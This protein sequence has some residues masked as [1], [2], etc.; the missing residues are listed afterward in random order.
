MIL[1]KSHQDKSQPSVREVVVITGGGSG[2]GLSAAKYM[3]KNKLIILSGRTMSKLEK[4]VSELEA[5]GY[6]ALAHTCD[7]SSRRSVHELA[8]FAALQGRITNVINAA[9]L[10]PSMADPETLLRV[11]ALGTMYINQ[12]FA[13]VMHSGS[14]IL[15]VSSNSAY[16]LPG[17]VEKLARRSYAVAQK[18][19][20]KFMKKMLRFSALPRK[21]YARR[22]FAYALSKNFVCWYASVS[23]FELGEK[24]IRVLSLSPGLISTDMGHLEEKEGEKMLRESAEH[25]MGTPEELGFCIAMAADERNGYLTGVDILADGGAIRHG[26]LRPLIA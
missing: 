14:V 11:N 4:A 26:Q 19:E 15:D 7:T 2:M 12:E 24:G 9:G 25:R 20:D 16:A 10:S 6:Q 21:E 8:A 1:E 13:K 23:A 22:G 3:P 17:F 18:S 5:L